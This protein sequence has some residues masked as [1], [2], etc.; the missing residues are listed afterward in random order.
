MGVSPF[1][2]LTQDLFMQTDTFGGSLAVTLPRA[3]SSLTYVGF[4]QAGGSMYGYS[5][6][7]EED[8]VLQTVNG[9]D[10][11]V[12]AD[13]TVSPSTIFSM[14]LDP[15]IQHTLRVYNILSDQPDG[16]SQISFNTLNVDIQDDQAGTQPAALPSIPPSQADTASVAPTPPLLPTS[17]ASSTSSTSLPSTPTSPLSSASPTTSGSSSVKVISTS[18]GTTSSGVTSTG[19]KTGS[20]TSTNSPSNPGPIL[21]VTSTAGAGSD[22]TTASSSSGGVSKSVVIGISI[23]AAVFVAALVAGLIVFLRQRQEK[24]RNSF[25]SSQPP[26]PS[27]SIIPIMPVPPPQMRTA[28][29]NPFSDPSSMPERTLQSP[30]SS[31][32]MQR[33]ME[34]RSASP[35]DA[36]TIPLP[37]I[38][39][40]WRDRTD[41]RSDSPATSFVPRNDLWI[42]RSPARPQFSVV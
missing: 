22:S 13:A 18:V 2:E 5:L 38:P 29:L 41:G 14:N 11:S 39:V 35:G 19:T 10:P 40:D 17:S 8:C 24:R 30:V 32:L 37:D 28:S 21:P 9:S 20:S 26:S 15:S 3:A 31:S 23:L 6:D 12:T 33:R 34:S 25:Q 1:S 27:G 36:P 7:C 4:K 42:T 16:S